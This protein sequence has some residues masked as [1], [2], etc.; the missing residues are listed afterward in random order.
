M[1]KLVFALL[2]PLILSSGCARHYYSLGDGTIEIFLK[3]P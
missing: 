2:V 3:A 1:K